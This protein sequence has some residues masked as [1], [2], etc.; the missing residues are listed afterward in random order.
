MTFSSCTPRVVVY[1]ESHKTSESIFGKLY[2]WEFGGDPIRCIGH[3][4]PSVRLLGSCS[5][6]KEDNLMDLRLWRNPYKPIEN[7]WLLRGE[8][9]VV[10]GWTFEFQNSSAWIPLEGVDEKVLIPNS[11][12]LSYQGGPCV[13]VC[14]LIMRL[15]WLHAKVPLLETPLGMTIV[16]SLESFLVVMTPI[17]VNE[18]SEKFSCCQDPRGVDEL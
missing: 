14:S 1:Q 10:S 18:L 4:V 9:L 11:K 5:S 17:G 16:G 7:R 6:G 8:L 13:D 2:K 15:L 12:P 3:L